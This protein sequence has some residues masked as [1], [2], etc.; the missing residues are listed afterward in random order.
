MLFGLAVR[1]LLRNDRRSALIAVIVAG[2]TLIAAV[3]NS[4]FE[5]SRVGLK[6]TFV[7]S[8][9]EDLF[10]SVVT[11]RPLSIFGEDTPVVG[12]YSPIAPLRDASAIMRIGRKTPGVASVVPQ[13]SEYA[14]LQTRGRYCQM[15]CA[16]ISERPSRIRFQRGIR[17]PTRSR[18]FVVAPLLRPFLLPSQVF[19]TGVWIYGH[20]VRNG[21]HFRRLPEV[22]RPRTFALA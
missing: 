15:L 6:K 21:V 22:R 2:C 16:G 18:S 4:F 10:V 19:R 7:D 11:G 5:S 9:T 8:F 3:G 12:P 1:N 20:R 17:I 14:L 13:I